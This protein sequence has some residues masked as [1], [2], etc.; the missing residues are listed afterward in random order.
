MSQNVLNLICPI[1]GQSDP[2]WGKIWSPYAWQ[3]TETVLRRATD[4]IA[5]CKHKSGQHGQDIHKNS[6]FYRRLSRLV[7]VSQTHLF[8]SVMAVREARVTGIVAV[9]FV[10]RT[11]LI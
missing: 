3:R 6:Q 7:T 8:T 1:R 4:K 10:E 9:R 2:L 5:L 11:E